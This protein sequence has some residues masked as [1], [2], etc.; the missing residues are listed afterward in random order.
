MFVIQLKHFLESC[1]SNLSYG[2][3]VLPLK[4]SL[5]HFVSLKLLEK[6]LWAYEW[7]RKNLKFCFLF[8]SILINL[9]LHAIF[10]KVYSL[11]LLVEIL[12]VLAIFRVTHFLI[13]KCLELALSELIFELVENEHLLP[14][15]EKQTLS[16][17]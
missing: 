14:P 2:N 3:V 13:L 7:C 5:L 11:K 8:D 1:L 16:S 9:L 4:K 6:T 12:N 15:L 17:L 10:V